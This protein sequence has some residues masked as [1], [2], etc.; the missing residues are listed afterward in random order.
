[1]P[2]PATGYNGRTL[3]IL[4]EG[5]VVA[6]V[7]S[8]ELTHNRES[9]DVTN[10]DSDGWRRL[11]DEPGVKSLDLS[12]EGVC[13]VANMNLWINKWNGTTYEDVAVVYPDGT[14]VTAAD[15]FLLSGLT[16]GAEH[17]AHVSFSAELQ[18]SGPIDIDNPG[19]ASS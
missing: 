8:R 1:M 9:V 4:I 14:V 17:N 6:A 10:D 3:K 16:I 5:E 13:T 15:G 11:L 7:Q 12:V 18:S 2:N 19:A